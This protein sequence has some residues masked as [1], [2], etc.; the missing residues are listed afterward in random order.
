MEFEQFS[1]LFFLLFVYY[2]VFIQK[3]MDNGRITKNMF[4]L[5]ERFKLVNSLVQNLKRNRWE[6]EILKPFFFGVAKLGV[7]NK[8]PRKQ[9]EQNIFC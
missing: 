5:E 2:V 1:L 3:L 9:I 7:A 4:F 8:K 6:I